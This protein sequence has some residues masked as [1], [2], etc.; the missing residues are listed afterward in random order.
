MA[1]TG[2]AQARL[3]TDSDYI[4][5]YANNAQGQVIYEGAAEPGTLTTAATWR[6]KKFTYDNKGA[7]TSILFAGGKKNFA[8]TWTGRAAATYS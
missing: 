3:Q 6:I 5:M 7:V 1:T 4:Y 2:T 8:T